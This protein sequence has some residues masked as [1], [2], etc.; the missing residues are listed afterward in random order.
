MNTEEKPPEIK[1]IGKSGRSSSFVLIALLGLFLGLVWL[2]LFDRAEVRD[3][4]SS[5]EARAGLNGRHILQEGLWF[6]P[7]RADDLPDLQKPPGYYWAVA[8]FGKVFQGVDPW[9][10]RLPSLLSGVLCAAFLVLIGREI[11]D[12]LAGFFGALVLLT[13]SHFVWA[14]RIGRIDM[15]LAAIVVVFTFFQI[16]QWK[17]GLTSDLFCS[18]II[19]GT[20][21]LFKGPISLALCI[22]CS[23][24]IV[25]WSFLFKKQINRFYIGQCIL[26]FLA[27]IFLS[28]P[29]FLSA[30]GATSGD[31]SRL[32]FVEHNWDRGM[33][34]GRLRSHPLWFYI[35][36]F[37]L[38]FMPWPIV[39]TIMFFWI[40]Y[41]NNKLFFAF[42]SDQIGFCAIWFALMFGMFTACGYKRAD[43]LLPAYPAAALAVGLWFR[44]LL[45]IPVGKL[46]LGSGIYFLVAGV[47][48]GV[49]GIQVWIGVWLPRWESSRSSSEWAATIQ[50]IIPPDEPVIF[51]AEEA[52]AVAFWL[53]R[54]HKV[55]GDAKDIGAA[56]DGNSR[57]WV[58][59]NPEV[60]EIWPDGPRPF[61][62]EAISKNWVSNE[63]VHKPL[64]LLETRLLKVEKLSKLMDN[65]PFE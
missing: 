58:I 12:P 7:G 14:S 17:F 9:A 57:V 39:L 27:G 47:L 44:S 10:I 26:V 29:W 52:H 22:V 38:D 37:L 48:F 4:W 53:A 56:L 28:L 41:R 55:S 61:Q 13:A 49:L 50:K 46:G 2:Q 36:Q 15:P 24:A 18:A 35:P 32:F 64:V 1:S 16:R 31:F 42:F 3:L 40:Y 51:F 25:S 6:L 59:T 23:F 54:K 62:W 65:F 19:V 60:L 34:T 8:A 43:Y 33:G 21:I 30:H 5:H 45:Q 20:G 63:P 11:G